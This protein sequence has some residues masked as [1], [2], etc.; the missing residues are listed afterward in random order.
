M[1]AFDVQAKV[2]A[3]DHRIGREEVANRILNSRTPSNDLGIVVV[4]I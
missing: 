4:K 3:Q 1:L 2:K